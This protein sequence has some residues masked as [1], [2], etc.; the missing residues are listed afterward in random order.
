MT[1]NLNPFEAAKQ[2]SETLQKAAVEEREQILRWVAESLGV[3]PPQANNSQL[4]RDGEASTSSRDPGNGEQNAPR[5][6]R[7]LD[8]RSFVQ[9]KEPKSNNQFAAVVAYY[10]RFEAPDELR[11]NTIK[12]NDLIEAT[13]KAGRTRMSNPGDTLKKAMQQGY[14]DQAGRGEYAI[15]TVGENLVAMTLPGGAS[16]GAK[17]S[18]TSSRKSKSTKKSASKKKTKKKVSRNSKK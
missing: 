2:I 10:Y 3:K 1:D 6:G 15:N 12:A 17:N 11:S 16:T 8:I 9:Q 7:T 4:Q 13:R 5:S 18:S 14:L